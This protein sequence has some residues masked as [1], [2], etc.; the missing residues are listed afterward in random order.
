MLLDIPVIN[1]MIN[2][3]KNDIERQRHIE[4]IHNCFEYHCDWCDIKETSKVHLKTHQKSIHEGI[5][6]CQ[7]KMI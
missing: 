7:F 4:Y 3:Q 5:N 1:V 2:Q 6:L